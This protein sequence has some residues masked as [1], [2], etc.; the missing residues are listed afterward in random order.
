V[1]ET[2]R[3][4]P[5]GRLLRSATGVMERA[6]REGP[7]DQAEIEVRASS[8]GS[9]LGTA[10]WS[11]AGGWAFHA[12]VKANLVARGGGYASLRVTRSW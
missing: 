10:T 12:D 9:I 4:T 6:L 5:Q 8:D 7:K 11:R 2:D 1:S 3:R